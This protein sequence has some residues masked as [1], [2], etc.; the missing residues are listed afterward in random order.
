MATKLL[1]GHPRR[2]GQLGGRHKLL[3]GIFAASA[4]SMAARAFAAA[5]ACPRATLKVLSWPITSLM[6]LGVLP[7]LETVYSDNTLMVSSDAKEFI[8]QHPQI[9]VVYGT[10]SLRDWWGNLSKPW[11]IVLMKEANLARI[12]PSKEEMAK[13]ANITKVNRSFIFF[14]YYTSNPLFSIFRI[15]IFFSAASLGEPKITL[16]RLDQT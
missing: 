8:T 11:K 14:N 7:N 12:N 16:K 4:W 15:N 3:A 5:R 13:V 9:L 6:P 10:E 1:S 2:L